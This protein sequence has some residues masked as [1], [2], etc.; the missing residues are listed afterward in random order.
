MKE[1]TK[2]LYAPKPVRDALMGVRQQFDR[3][4]RLYA[5]IFHELFAPWM[6][7]DL[8]GSDVDEVCGAF[9]CAYMPEFMD[10]W[11]EWHGPED[12]RYFGRFYGHYG[13]GLYDFQRLAESAYLVLQS[14]DRCLSDDGYHGWLKIVHDMAHSYPTPLLRSDSDTWYLEE[15][16]EEVLESYTETDA[17]IRYPLHPLHWVLKHDV[18]ASSMAAIDLILDPDRAILVGDWIDEFPVCFGEESESESRFDRTVTDSGLK[19]T[20]MSPRFNPPILQFRFDGSWHLAFDAGTSIE[21]ATIP[22]RRRDGLAVYRTLIENPGKPFSW[23][24][25]LRE[26]SQIQTAEVGGAK[27]DDMFDALG[28]ADLREEL[29]RLEREIDDT[30][31]FERRRKLE[32]EQKDLLKT[33]SVTKD[34]WGRPRKLGQ[35]RHVAAIQMQL[36]RARD[37][38]KDQMPQFAEYL[39][40]MVSADGTDFKYEPLTASRSG[41]FVS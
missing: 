5:P 26:T 18:F 14:V 22:Q 35:K 30:V 27:P 21:K 34:R 10:Q 9:Y 1:K 23:V 32:E 17:G 8:G 19:E 3:C 15:P 7:M 25:L 37:R 41:N 6:D 39:R 12:A 16:T 4:S 38:I 29:Q 20:E 2:K 11:Q 13:A 31:D 36:K 24:T 28:L 33:A 40:R